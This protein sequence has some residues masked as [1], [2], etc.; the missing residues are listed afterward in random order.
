MF[1]TGQQ[2]QRVILQKQKKYMREQ[3][4]LARDFIK[5]LMENTA[6]I[7]RMDLKSIKQA[8]LEYKKSARRLTIRRRF[9]KK[10]KAVLHR[11]N[12]R[13]VRSRKIYI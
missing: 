3:R 13:L 10:K 5:A 2:Q 4:G 11:K 6:A 12:I 9:L 1:D 8:K 7:K